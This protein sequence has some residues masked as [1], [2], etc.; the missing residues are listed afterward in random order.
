MHP[1]LLQ[2]T[3]PIYNANIVVVAKINEIEKYSN[4]C[5]GEYSTWHW[6]RI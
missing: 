4:I 6:H 1:D 2:K 3:M 5:N